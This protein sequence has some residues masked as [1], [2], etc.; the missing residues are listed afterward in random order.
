MGRFPNRREE[1]DEQGVGVRLDAL[2]PETCTSE[3]WAF[4]RDG[5]IATILKRATPIPTTGNRRNVFRL[6]TPCGKLQDYCA[7][8]EE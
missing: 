6:V 5:R 1:T 7:N 3:R 4:A 2:N 8:I